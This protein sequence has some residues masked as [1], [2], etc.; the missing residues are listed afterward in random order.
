[1]AVA[2][3]LFTLPDTQSWEPSAVVEVA[4]FFFYT[5]I[6]PAQADYNRLVGHGPHATG[7]TQ[8]GSRA[9]RPI[10]TCMSD[11]QG[12]Y[13]VEQ[14]TILPLFD[15]RTQLY[16]KLAIAYYDRCHRADT[17]PSLSSFPGGITPGCD[18]DQ[19]TLEHISS[20]VLC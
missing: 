14:G 16:V 9:R 17:Y 13:Q 7:P 10:K 6:E 11:L 5:A 19:L 12:Y 4:R 3:R 20:G 18:P 8:I 1:M 2:K 15:L